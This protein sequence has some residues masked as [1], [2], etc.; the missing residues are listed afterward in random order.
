MNIGDIILTLKMKRVKINNFVTDPSYIFPLGEKGIRETLTKIP[1]Q[2]LKGLESIVIM[3]PLRNSDFNNYARY[4]PL[5]RTIYLFAHYRLPDSTLMVGDKP[6]KQSYVRK[7]IKE[8]VIFHEVGHHVGIKKKGDYS[9]KFAE[10]Y[11]TRINP[12]L[13]KRQKR[14]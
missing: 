4:D 13:R 12:K 7:K 6:K 2:D 5:Q 11:A 9:E 1:Q 14:S 10:R 8:D 3:Q